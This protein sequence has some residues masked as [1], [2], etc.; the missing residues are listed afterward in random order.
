MDA[1]SIIGL[2]VGK[3]VVEAFS[4]CAGKA[5]HWV[6]RCDCGNRVIMRRGNLM[7]NRT[8][9]SC[10]CSRFSH[11]MTGTPTYSSWSNMI[12]RCTNPSNKRY[13]DYQGRGITVCERWMTFANFLANMGERPDATS[14]DRIDN[15]AGY[16]KENCRWATAL[17]QMN[18]TRRNTFVEYLG[19]RQTVSQWA[20]QLGIP[21]CTLRSRLNRGWS[22]EDAMQKPISKQRREC[23]Q[24]KG[25]RRG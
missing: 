18:N 10:G 5:S 13:V 16:F 17:E 14:L 9:T 3:V 23:K 2:R 19:R 1:E 11:G 8:T 6:C 22:I 24:K 7:R 15:D 12:D 25:K 4:H 21:E 20:G